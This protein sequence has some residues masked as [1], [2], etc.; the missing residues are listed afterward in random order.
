MA[1]LQVALDFV[2]LARAIEAAREA[3][4]GGADILE[5]GTPLI[6]SE[7]LEAVRRLRREFPEAEIVAD[8]KTIDAGRTEAEVASKAGANW[9]IVMGSASDSTIRECVDAGKN[10][11]IGIGV[12]LLGCKEP[13]G[14]A[15]E[16][17][18]LG[19]GL[20]NVHTPIDD[21]MAGR[22]PFA[23]LRKVRE[24]VGCLVSVAGGIHSENVVEAV[25]G[26]ADIVIV[27]GAITKA[28]DA[29][30]ATGAIRKAM[31]TGEAVPTTLFKRAGLGEVRGVF[32]RVSTA[33]LSD[34]MHRRGAVAGIRPV[35]A[36]RKLVGR[37]LTV[38]TYPGDWAKPVEAIERATEGE[39]IVIDAGGVPPAVWGELASES[40]VQ[41]KLAGV[42]IDGAIRDTEEIQ[43]IG[44]SAY[45]RMV[46]P[47]AGEPKGLGEIGVPIRV[48]GVE[49]ETGDWVI[50]DGDGVVVVSAGRSVEI[51]NRA[52]DV[53]EKENRIREE[54]RRSKTLSEVTEILKWEKV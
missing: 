18:A 17:E 4:A 11:G 27:G 28:K 26:G 38:R 8:M 2:D 36:G 34:A 15:R 45:A 30:A 20:V 32:E 46:T 16:V 44:F 53:L 1:R 54:I 48:G 21:Q 43:K 13:V 31:A 14:R 23:L 50:G 29:T 22:D 24:A 51:A 35:G 49:V 37:A 7:G 39:V 19:A 40:C 25:S 9:M 41:R 42:V 6:K 52:M 47:N 12:D 33:N 5:A 10:Y 3:M